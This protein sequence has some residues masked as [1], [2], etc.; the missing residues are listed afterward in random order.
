[1]FALLWW[2]WPLPKY[3]AETENTLMFFVGAYA[4]T[5]LDHRA[6]PDQPKRAAWWVCILLGVPGI[7][8]LFAL[9][10]GA[11]W[12][13]KAAH[14]PPDVGAACV[15]TLL[16]FYMTAIAPFVFRLLGVGREPRVPQDQGLVTEE[17][18]R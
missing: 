2:S 8:G 15:A 17:P 9:Q 12:A 10:I 11:T 7:V 1:L 3:P 13:V 6:M 14:L 18:A 4:G 5:I 16:G